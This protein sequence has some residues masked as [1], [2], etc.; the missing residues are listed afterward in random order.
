M[1]VATLA[2]GLGLAVHA[3]YIDRAGANAVYMD[4]L[5]LLW[6]WSEFRDGNLSLLALWGQG[7]GAHSG[8]L[9]QSVLAANVSWFG[10]DPLLANRS[11]GGVMA[12]VALLLLASYAI[13]LRR[14]DRNVPVLSQVMVILAVAGLCFSLAGFE[15]MTLDLGLGLWLKNLLIFVLF[16]AHAETLRRGKVPSLTTSFALAEGHCQLPPQQR[17]R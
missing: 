1:S 13:D 8:L 6:Q 14:S 2:V 11:T 7:G 5:R 10:L 15:L 12:V 3:A 16:L 9:F 17:K 4:T